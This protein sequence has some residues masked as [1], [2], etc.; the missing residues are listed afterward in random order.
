MLLTKEVEINLH[1]FNMKHYEN[2]GYKIP[3]RLDRFKRMSVPKGSKIKVKVE[4][5]PEKSDIKIELK[6]D[7]C[8]KTFQ[9]NYSIY[10]K[11]K[12]YNKEKNKDA[13]RDCKGKKI[14]DI[15]TNNIDVVINLFE[16][17]NFKIIN[18][19]DTYENLHSKFDLMCEN[20]HIW[21]TSVSNFKAVLKC[22]ECNGFKKWSYEDIKIFLQE[23]DCVLLTKEN[24]Y[25]NVNEEITYICKCGNIHT[26]AFYL[27]RKAPNCP[28][29]NPYKKLYTTKIVRDILNEDDY[30]LLSEYKNF[31]SPLEYICNKGHYN[32]NTSL[33]NYLNGARCMQ[34]YRENN[35][36]E[37]NPR[38]N[39]N[40]TM[41]ER[42]DDR[43]Y[44]EYEQWRKSVFERDN[45][46]CQSCGDNK[47]GNLIAHHKDAYSW[48]KERRLDV[49]N[50]VTL[51]ENCHALNEDSFHRMYGFINNTEEQFNE[52]LTI[53]N[54]CSLTL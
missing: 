13:C 1:S 11:S 24:E 49:N 28:K 10:L 44:N 23:H 48:C 31:H 35:F 12:N 50:G 6:C 51:C 26:K 16:E 45:Y 5:L 7:Y 47:G 15:L 9:R 46:T 8:G 29:C 25:K 38:W 14:S 37:N 39:H 41:E 42:L 18:G 3:R 2:L 34:C 33:S 27:F 30:I 52:W 54:V 53:I 17:N 21:T 32:N 43:K 20:K 22:P 4:D 40:K 19:I 36:G